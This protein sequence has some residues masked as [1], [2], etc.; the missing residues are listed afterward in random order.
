MTTTPNMGLTQPTVGVDT[1]VTWEQA[2]NSNS[3]TIDQHNHSSGNGVPITPSGI[4]INASLPFG[5]NPATALQAAVFQSQPSLATLKAV[6]VIGN[7]LYYNDGAGNIV[8][9]TSGG[10]VNATSSGISSGTAS[11]SFVASVLVV[12]AASNTPANIQCG[13]VLLGNN[14]SGSKFLTLSPPAAMAA[15][16]AQ[17]LPTIPA[18]TS[19]MQMDTS[20]NMSATAAVSHGIT[21]AMIVTP[22]QQI[23]SNNN[24]TTS[25][26][27][28]VAVSGSSVTLTTNGNP[29]LIVI[30]GAFSAS[31]GAT[32][33]SGYSVGLSV[34]GS[35]FKNFGPTEWY[36]PVG[37]ATFAGSSSYVYMDTPTAGTYTYGVMLSSLSS[38]VTAVASAAWITA[39][40]LL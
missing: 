30:N 31:R 5:N 13:S 27:S 10:T 17:T 12:N 35:L 38:S 8:Q 19:F 4:S 28:F 26:G 22:G 29:V 14:T 34:G 21:R 15:N 20:G 25:T 11:A 18:T 37:G 16:I 39:Y 33:Q 36:D 40:E 6:Y 1:G 7:D 23:S 2:I 9:I 32:G 3:T 24:L